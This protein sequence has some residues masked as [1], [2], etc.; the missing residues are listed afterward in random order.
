MCNLGVAT[1][2]RNPLY[3]ATGI[4]FL[5]QTLHQRFGGI[6]LRQQ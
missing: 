6:A 4:D 2:D 3:P 1:D 5:H